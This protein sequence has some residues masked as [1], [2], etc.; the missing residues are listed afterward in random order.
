MTAVFIRETRDAAGGK[1]LADLLKLLIEIV[2]VYGAGPVCV[3]SSSK[4][5]STGYYWFSI[6]FESRFL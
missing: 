4:T 6:I 2:S 3:S 5:V 1:L